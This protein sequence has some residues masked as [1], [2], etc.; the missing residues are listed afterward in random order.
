MVRIQEF[1]DRKG[2]KKQEE[3]A[4]I[5]GLSQSAI[6]AWNAGTNAPKHRTC[7]QLLKMGMTFRELFGEDFPDIT[8]AD[9]KE[10][11]AGT[12][13]EKFEKDTPE[14]EFDKK[15]ED[16]VVRLLGNLFAKK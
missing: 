15:V 9:M 16:S 10:M 6:S 11:S 12:N 1:M 13:V 2:I 8:L 4:S 5:L 14:H 7:V 3:L